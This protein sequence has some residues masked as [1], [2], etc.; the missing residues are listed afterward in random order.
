MNN[1]F[2]NNENLNSVN[3]ENAAP[4]AAETAPETVETAEAAPEQPKKRKKFLVPVIICAVVVLLAAIVIGAIAIYNAFFKK[5]DVQNLFNENLLCVRDGDQWGY[6]NKNG[7]YVIK[8]K[9]DKAYNFTENGIARIAQF[10]E[11]ELAY[12]Y[13]YINKKGD[14]IVKAK[15]K[16]ARDF[17]ECGL[18]A[19]M[20]E[21]GEW[22]A[23]DKN[24]EVVINLK[25][26]GIQIYDSG[27]I[28][29]RS[30]KDKMF[31]VDKKGEEI[32]EKYDS[33]SWYEDAEIGVVY[34]DDECGIINAK[35]KEVME[36]T[37]DFDSLGGFN[38]DGIGRYREDDYYGIIN[39]KG[40]IITKADYEYLSSFNENGLAIFGEDDEYGILNARGKEVVKAGEYADF[41]R[42]NDGWFLAIDEEGEVITVLN[43]KCKEVFSYEEDGDWY[44]ANDFADNG[45]APIMD[46]DD[47]YGFINRKG[48]VVIDCKYESASSFSSCGLARV[49]EE[50]DEEF[51]FIN[52]KG[53]VV[54]GS[55]LYAT[56]Y[57]DDGYA[58]AVEVDGGEIIIKIINDKGRLVKELECDD[59]LL[60][61]GVGVLSSAADYVVN[62]EDF[63][64]E[65]FLINYIEENYDEDDFGMGIDSA[66]EYVEQMLEYMGSDA[67]NQMVYNIL[68]GAEGIY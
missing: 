36:L 6:V 41:E 68:R 34:D 4:E 25:Y 1:G 18:A 32:S 26:A 27:V 40:K 21:D 42:I 65:E 15:Y 53:N 35:G 45:L 14:A 17:S 50:D 66:E 54:G 48:K 16:D 19:V 9:Y 31:L 8:A 11:D 20:N 47:L 63:D 33:I 13:G 23:I 60:P 62:S 38:E 3:P 57:F 37:D 22:G 43:E 56:S 39:A 24:G 52:A 28:I 2:D 58:V 59:V 5:D 7:K 12:N 64:H 44:M 10:D 30:S 61:S 29:V 46:D 51:R 49:R 67:I 55:Y